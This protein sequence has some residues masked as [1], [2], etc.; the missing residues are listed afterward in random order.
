MSK[1]HKHAA[2]I[3][4]WADGAEIEYLDSSK[5]WR[6]ID[7]ELTINWD[8]DGEFRVKPEY[9]KTRMTEKERWD[10]VAAAGISRFNIGTSLPEGAN[11]L[12]HSPGDVTEAIANAAIARA[13]Q[14]G[15]VVPA[16]AAHKLT[17]ADMVVY[18]T[19]KG[20][21]KV[22]E[23]GGV[24]YVPD[25]MLE[26]VAIAVRNEC[27]EQFTD[28]NPEIMTTKAYGRISN[29]NLTAIIERVKGGA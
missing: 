6:G 22:V 9:P 29:V 8:G 1:P 11:R 25:S 26:K 12:E 24:E 5:A 13:I 2:V 14:D 4:A 17:G 20:G 19:F 10:A 21:P 16:N 23:V 27:R 3:K 7:P 18:G 28:G 15:D